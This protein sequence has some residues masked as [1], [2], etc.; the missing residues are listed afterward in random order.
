MPACRPGDADAFEDRDELRGIAPLAWRD[1]QG[2][3]SASAF[4]GEVDLGD[5]AAPGPSE[6]LVGAVMP[7]R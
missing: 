1:Q 6:S 5:Q 3:G 2:K 7:G 4:T